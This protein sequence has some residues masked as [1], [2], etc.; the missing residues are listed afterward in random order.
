MFRLLA[1]VSLIFL[2]SVNA[3]AETVTCSISSTGNYATVALWEADGYGATIDACTESD[4]DGC[5]SDDDCVGEI[6]G[7]IVEAAEVRIDDSTPSSVHLTSASAGRHNGTAGTGA[8]IS[9]THGN[10]DVLD[11]RTALTISWLGLNKFSSLTSKVSRI[12]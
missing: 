9:V 7:T 4:G 8:A 12:F 10:G 5:D 1:I 2:F 3:F 11:I 6:T